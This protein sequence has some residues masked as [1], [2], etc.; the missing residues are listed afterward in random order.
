FRRKVV[1]VQKCLPAAGIARVDYFDHAALEFIRL[2]P[3]PIP[4]PAFPEAWPRAAA[5][6][7]AGVHAIVGGG[8]GLLARTRMAGSAGLRKYD[9][10]AIDLG[11]IARP[12]KR[13]R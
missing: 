7:D 1:A 4:I 11:R 6:A 9:L 8:H 10:S 13:D 2:R 3:G 12:Q 5:P